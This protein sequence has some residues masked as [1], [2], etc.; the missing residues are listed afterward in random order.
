MSKSVKIFSD[1]ITQIL[2]SVDVNRK[3]IMY[4]SITDMRFNSF[5]AQTSNPTQKNIRNR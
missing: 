3:Y 5:N 1:L 2:T 4:N